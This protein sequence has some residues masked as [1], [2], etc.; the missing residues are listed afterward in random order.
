MDQYP[1]IYNRGIIRP[2]IPTI[3]PSTRGEQEADHATT[4]RNRP[5]TGSRQRPAGRQRKTSRSRQTDTAPQAVVR[6]LQ[7]Q[8]RVQLTDVVA[9]FPQT[10]IVQQKEGIW[11]LVQSEVLD[12]LDR[13]AIFLLAL[14]YDQ[15][16]VV[17]AWGF[18][19]KETSTEWIGPRHTNFPDGSICAFD[20]SDLTW[21]PGDDI[22]KLL[23]YYSLWAARHLHIRDFGRW[24]GQQVAHH[25]YERRT[26]FR[27]DE[28]CGCSNRDKLYKD[29]CLLSD[30]SKDK[31]VDM[32]DFQSHYGQ[33]R[34]VPEFITEFA[35]N[36]EIEPPRFED[37]WEWNM[38]R[39][40]PTTRA[41][42]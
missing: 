38:K 23:G 3:S 21:V 13:T 1:Q 20:P 7:K 31:L 19:K 34:A 14:P 35:S 16:R 10:K 8:Y 30:L 18:W 4:K 40:P 41:K 5:S 6:N 42:H 25:S 9:A 28:Y 26:E 24:P 11:L 33:I 37:I 27:P 32:L 29:C 39:L 22:G 12:G 17:R 36:S 15:S 2:Q